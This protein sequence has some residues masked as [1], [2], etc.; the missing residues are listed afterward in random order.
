LKKKWTIANY[1]RPVKGGGSLVWVVW[2]LA[3]LLL[4]CAGIV[5]RVTAKQLKL[6]V[7]A[8]IK[9]PYPLSTFSTE[10]GNWNG[11]DVPIPYNIQRIAGNDDFLN[12]LYTNEMTKEWANVYIAYSARPR[13]MLGH[14]PQA[15]YVGNGWIHD[16]T[17]LSKFISASGA[18]IPCLIH[19]F[20]K[21]APD[22]MKVVVLNFYILNGQ[23]T[24]DESSFSG[25][26]WRTPNIAGNPARYVA[27]VQI[28]STAENST[29][30]AAKDMTDLMITFFPDENGKVKAAEYINT[31]SSIAK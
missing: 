3:I 13:T 28:S 18:T 29:R 7:D 27:Q 21:P 20:H 31:R 8:S 22:N 9:L 25:V 2:I 23:I 5:Y 4:L 15:C 14:K 16:S 1:T 19:R 6:V 17:E 24:S 11:K 12:R 30:E 26:G 10:V